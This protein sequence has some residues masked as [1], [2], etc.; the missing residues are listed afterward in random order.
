MRHPR[1]ADY[2]RPTIPDAEVESKLRDL[3]ALIATTA[4]DPI[5]WHRALENYVGRARGRARVISDYDYGKLAAL[6]L[7]CM[8]KQ[9]PDYP[10]QESERYSWEAR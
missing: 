6:L 8:H 4:D 3:A 10:K 1:Y 7:R 5:A 9:L 2:Y